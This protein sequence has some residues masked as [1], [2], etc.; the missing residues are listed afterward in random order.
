MD[1]RRGFDGM[2]ENPIRVS[3]L[4][5]MTSAKPPIQSSGARNNT[6]SAA[7]SRARVPGGPAIRKAAGAD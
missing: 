2:A 4:D 6:S 3:Q 1:D 5:S 7:S